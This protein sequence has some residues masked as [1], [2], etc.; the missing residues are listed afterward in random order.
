VRSKKGLLGGVQAQHGF[1]DFG[2]DVFDGFEHAFAQ[3]PAL[4]AVAQLNGFAAAR[5]CARRHSGT[6]HDARFQQHVAFDGGVATAVEDFTADDIND[7]T[8]F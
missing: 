7:C 6:A 3:I 5:G 1:G 2:V 8:H 4:V